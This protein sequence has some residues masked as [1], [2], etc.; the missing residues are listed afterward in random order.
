MPTFFQQPAR[1]VQLVSP[2]N[3]VILCRFGS[4]VAKLKIFIDVFVNWSTLNGKKMSQRFAAARMLPVRS[5]KMTDQIAK[6]LAS[7]VSLTSI[8]PAVF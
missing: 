1:E 2:E 4:F 5:P 8:N 6:S 7:V 3:P